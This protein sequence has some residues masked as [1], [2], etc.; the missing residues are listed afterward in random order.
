MWH[1]ASKNQPYPDRPDRRTVGSHRTSLRWVVGASVLL[2]LVLALPAEVAQA[3]HT[4]AC[5]DITN[6]ATATYYIGPNVYTETSNPITTV[7]AELLDVSV[8]WQDASYVPAS[9]GS[10]NKVLTFLVTNTGNGTDDYTLEGISTLTG[11]DFDPEFV[12]IHLDSNDNGVFDSGIDEEYVPGVNDPSLGADGSIIVFVLNDIPEPLPNGAL[13]NSK[14]LATSNTGNGTPGTVIPEGGDCENDAVV[15]VSGG[16]D[17]DVG[18]YIISSIQL[19]VLKSASILDPFGGSQPV[20]GAVITYTLIVSASGTDTAVDVVITDPVPTH[21]TY[22]AG[23]L[24]LNSG[25]LTD[26]A[27]ADAGDVGQTTANTV[28]VNL[29]DVLGGTP[30]QTITFAATID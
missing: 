22:N 23:T 27:D 4:P 11:D 30:A 24:T 15:G 12:A 28:T 13:G 7:V 1:F 18:T 17:E 3:Q 25:S 19:S 21:T 5:T 2:V 10:E 20:P 26:E 14:L 6:Q 16:A 8:V 9:P 29:G